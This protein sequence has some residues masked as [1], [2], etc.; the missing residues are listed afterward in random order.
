MVEF[1]VRA[2]GKYSLIDHSFARVLKGAIGSLTVS[3]PSQPTVFQV[4]RLAHS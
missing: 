1:T 2:P 4:V 3:G